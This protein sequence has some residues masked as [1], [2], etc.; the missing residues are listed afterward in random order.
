MIISKLR[1]CA[2]VLVAAFALLAPPVQAQLSLG[3]SAPAQD[4]PRIPDPLTPDT[5]NALISRLS[6]SEVRALLLD[7][8]NIQAEAQSAK[9]ASGPSEL[10]YHATEGAWQSVVV[11]IER[12]PALISG[13]ARA[14]ST[15]YERIGGGSGLWVPL[16]KPY[17]GA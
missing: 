2:L 6:D 16:Q 14:F 12:I 1:A 7:Q 4:A 11:P 10:L 8:L 9:A 3:S 5:A 13:Q 17:S 15:F